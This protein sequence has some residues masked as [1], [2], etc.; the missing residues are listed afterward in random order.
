V[1]LTDVKQAIAEKTKREV[2]AVLAAAAAEAQRIT[3]DAQ[4]QIR[5]KQTLH[6]TKQQERLEALERKEHAAA[7]FIRKSTLLEEKRKAMNAVVERT[8]ESLNTMKA[9]E[10][11]KLLA[12]LAKSAQE[13]ITIKQVRCN[14]KDVAALGKLLPAA[15]I[16]ADEQVLGGFLADD[17]S[18]TV[19]VDYTY[20]T[21][22]D[23]VRDASMAELTETLFS[24]R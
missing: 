21:L 18:G 16:T 7:Q 20:H 19:R 1:G 15:T 12:T 9:D 22:M 6:K 13:T 3:K 5:V 17:A 24:T 14:K 11:N 8:L 4:E 10:R 23:A 2:D